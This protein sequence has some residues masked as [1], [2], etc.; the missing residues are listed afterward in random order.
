MEQHKEDM[1]IAKATRKPSHCVCGPKPLADLPGFDFIKAFV[2]EYMHSCCQGVFKLMIKLWTFQKYSKEPWSVR[3]KLK[4]LN[5]RLLNTKPPYEITRVMIA[6][7]D[8]SDWKAS[9]FRAFVILYVDVLEDVLPKEFFDH[10]VN[11]SY[12]MFV[13]LQEKVSV[14]DVE[15]I[16]VLFRPFLIDFEKLYGT[17]H[18]RINVH[19]LI[20]LSQSV[21]DWGCL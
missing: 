13:L 8:L 12:G 18:V 15:K 4:V 20:Y 6:L 16:K 21:L 7:D 17:T 10:F 5:S 9:M 3:G 11:L 2:P 14:S 19:F 1:N